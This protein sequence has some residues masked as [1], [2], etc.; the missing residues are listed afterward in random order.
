MIL[1]QIE[2]VLQSGKKLVGGLG[3]PLGIPVAGL[4]DLVR[5]LRKKRETLS[6]RRLAIVR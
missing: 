3:I 2:H 1:N 4:F 5:D 6:P